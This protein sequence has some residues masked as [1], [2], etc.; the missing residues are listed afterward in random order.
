[1][2]L[3]TAEKNEGSQNWFLRCDVSDI[4]GVIPIAIV[5]VLS[6]SRKTPFRNVAIELFPT[7]VEGRR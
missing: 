5:S 1:V 6:F 2:T 3:T 4:T 7:N